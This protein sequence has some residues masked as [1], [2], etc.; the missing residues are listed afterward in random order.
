MSK[1]SA[2][3]RN[4]F[5]FPFQSMSGGFVNAVWKCSTPSDPKDKINVRINPG[6]SIID[7][8]DRDLECHVMTVLGRQGITLPVYGRFVEYHIIIFDD[9]I[10][11]TFPNKTWAVWST[12]FPMMMKWSTVCWI[13]PLSI[14]MILSPRRL[15]RGVNG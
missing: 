7:Q 9:V 11:I 14:E 3:W 2:E 10:I 8:V 15:T 12:G 4:I 13:K 1:S 6:S 5:T